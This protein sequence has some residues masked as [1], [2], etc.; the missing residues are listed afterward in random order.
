M[1]TPGR[2]YLEFTAYQRGALRHS[3]Q[4]VAV[5]RRQGFLRVKPGPGID[6]FQVELLVVSRH[7]RTL[8]SFTCA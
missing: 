4:P 8:T 5:G 7:R 3:A 1:P 2:F 6:H